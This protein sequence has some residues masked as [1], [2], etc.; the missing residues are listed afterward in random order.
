LAGR[1]SSRAG[2]E[3][4][5]VLAHPLAAKNTTVAHNDIQRANPVIWPPFLIPEWEKVCSDRFCWKHRPRPGP[6]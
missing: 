1:I 3:G 6:P 5:G 4:G 2:G